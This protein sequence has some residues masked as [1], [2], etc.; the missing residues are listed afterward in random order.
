VF[1]SEVLDVAIGLVF[2]Y[3]VLS[4]ICSAGCEL[5]EVFLKRRAVYLERG[6]RQLLNDPDGSGLV[7]EIYSHPLITS[8]F[9]GKYD[10]LRT[11]NLPSYI[12][13]AS[14]ALA[15]MD[16]VGLCGPRA[17]GIPSVPLLPAGVPPSPEF[18]RSTIQLNAGFSPHVS[19]AMLAIADAAGYNPALMRQEIETW[20]NSSMDRVSGWFKR[21]SHVVVLSLGLSLSLAIN[22][23]TISI[24]NGLATGKALREA[25]VSAA[26]EAAKNPPSA[27]GNGF[28][29]DLEQIRS[30]GLPLGWS[31][32]AT[33]ARRVPENPPE[34]AIKILGIILTGLAIS[35]GGPFWFDILNQFMVVRS[36]VKPSEK[37]PVEDTKS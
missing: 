12:P 34:W 26:S 23:D 35:L 15:L 22:A 2:V 16:I 7:K 29:A 6:L 32:S 24:T 11:G 37:S 4:L 5:I 14:F 33:D 20:Y 36:T 9:A 10:P 31:T 13:P 1:G 8:L 25:L 28:Q 27:G 21:H 17:S 18:V 3:L 30:A 19:Q